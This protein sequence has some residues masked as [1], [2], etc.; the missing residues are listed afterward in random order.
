MLLM[1]LP[2]S[3]APLGNFQNSSAYYL[4]NIDQ[5]TC[6]CEVDKT[7]SNNNIEVYRGFWLTFLLHLPP[8]LKD[9]KFG[10]INQIKKSKQC[11]HWHILKFLRNIRNFCK[12]VYKVAA[13]K[14]VQWQNKNGDMKSGQKLE[15]ATRGL[16]FIQKRLQHRC[17]PVNIA[18]VL[19]TPILKNIC[20]RLFLKIE[21]TNFFKALTYKSYHNFPNVH[22][23]LWI[24]IC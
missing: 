2:I 3:L 4:N 18:K 11:R 22:C 19:R 24:V 13:P 9:K 14:Y 6:S 10:Q 23:K 21:N 17:F 15:A 8:L 20:K 12:V 5:Y 16:H 1:T 7:T